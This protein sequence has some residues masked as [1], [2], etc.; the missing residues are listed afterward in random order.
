[1]VKLL[2]FLAKYL[3]STD[4]TSDKWIFPRERGIFSVVCFKDLL[5][6]TDNLKV[7][8]V[9]IM[10]IKTPSWFIITVAMRFIAHFNDTSFNLFN[11]IDHNSHMV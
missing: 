4:L 9:L 10:K 5:V 7:D 11:V 6:I 8:I 3:I 2:G 1:M